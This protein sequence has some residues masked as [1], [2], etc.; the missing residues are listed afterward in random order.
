MRSHTAMTVT[1]ERTGARRYATVV[2]VPGEPVRRAEPAPGFAPAFPHDLVHYLVEATLGMTH[3]VF[4][5]ALSGGAGLFLPVGDDPRERAREQRRRQRREAALAAADRGDMERSERLTGWCTVTWYRRGGAATPE[6]AR[7]GA[8]TTAVQTP[9][10]QV[11]V[12]RV[13][14]LLDELSPRWQALPVGGALQ[15][16]WP[17]TTAVV[18][19]A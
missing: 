8:G 16:T 6:W 3:G 7:R 19:G 11:V 13:V 17:D 1:F 15:F 4:G 10:D 5:R 2:S 18:L 9:E 12:D 14:A